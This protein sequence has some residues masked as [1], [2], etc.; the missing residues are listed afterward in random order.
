MKKCSTSLALKE[1]KIKMTL[2]F[3]LIPVISKKTN[4][5]CWQGFWKKELSYT[6]DGNVNLCC[7]YGNQCG[8]SS[9]D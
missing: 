8:D 1:M 5:K 2:R 9:E 6:V 7:Q 3:H 4:N